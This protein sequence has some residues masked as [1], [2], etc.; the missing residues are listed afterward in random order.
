MQ[1]VRL[2]RSGLKVSRICIGTNMFGAG[3]VNDDR[4]I[5]VVNEAHEQGINFI[6]TAAMYG[7]SEERIG[8]HISDRKDEF[9]VATKCGDYQVEEGGT[10]RVV[11]DYSPE[12]ITRTIDESRRK[13]KLD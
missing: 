7:V 5:S 12:G 9:I 8:R 13:L 10:W 1:Y 11:K 2:G 3:Y 6:D 4:A